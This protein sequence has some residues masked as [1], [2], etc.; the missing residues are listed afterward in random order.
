MTGE[1]RMLFQRGDFIS[2]SC[3]R[4]ASGATRLLECQS[5]EDLR[6]KH[7]VASPVEKKICRSA[8]KKILALEKEQG[9]GWRGIPLPER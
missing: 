2:A 5:L 8:E 7:G 3:R 1:A 9:I 4:A 6:L